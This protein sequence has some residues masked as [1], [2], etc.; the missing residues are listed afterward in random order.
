MKKEYHYNYT[1][2]KDIPKVEFVSMTR[3]GDV[4]VLVEGKPY[5]YKTSPEIIRTFRQMLD[6]GA[7]LKALNYLKKHDYNPK[8]KEIRTIQG[9]KGPY[10]AQ[11]W[12]GRTDEGIDHPGEV[13]D[14]KE[15]QEREK[16]KEDLVKEILEQGKG[17]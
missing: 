15:Y 12:V 13:M 6:K 10:M 17:K 11:R 3:D 8:R 1:K 5:E 14:E 16:I 2:S 9:K 4:K 7:N